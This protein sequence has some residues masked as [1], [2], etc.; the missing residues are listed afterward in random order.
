MESLLIPAILTVTLALISAISLPLTTAA[1]SRTPV[2]DAL[3]APGPS[4]GTA[5][6]LPPVLETGG[7]PDVTGTP[8]PPPMDAGAPKEY[9]TATFA[10]G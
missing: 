3:K 7:D 5:C 4:D 6:D 9:K 2:K 1:M 8:G 10:M